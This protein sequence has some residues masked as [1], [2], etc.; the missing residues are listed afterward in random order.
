MSKS[1]IKKH[2]FNSGEDYTWER[3]FE[4]S[5]R[6]NIILE[7]NKNNANLFPKKQTT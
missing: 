3:E 1:Y 2:P 4:N 7:V 6:F 5:G